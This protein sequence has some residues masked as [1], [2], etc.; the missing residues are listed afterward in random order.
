MVA[1]GGRHAAAYCKHEEEGGTQQRELTGPT[2]SES[3]VC[4]TPDGEH[5]V[6]ESDD[7]TGRARS[8]ED[9][10]LQRE[11]TGHTESGSSSGS[12]TIGW[13]INL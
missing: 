8:L 9:G 7:K 1:G 10:T 5:F 11:L 12:A 13:H 6:A 3:S 2:E 4:A